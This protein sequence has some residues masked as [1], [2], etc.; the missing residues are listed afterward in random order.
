MLLTVQ[1][2]HFVRS[3]EDFPFKKINAERELT[4]PPSL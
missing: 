4:V 1:K 2:S 3:N